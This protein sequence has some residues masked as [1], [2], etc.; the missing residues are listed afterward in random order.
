MPATTAPS[1]SG[2]ASPSPRPRRER[3]RRSHRAGDAGRRRLL[4]VDR[5]AVEVAHE[6]LLR[7]WPRL[8]TWLDEDVQG[9]RLH[10]RLGDA[11]R[12]WETNDQDPSELY[13]GTRLDGAVDWAAGHDADLNDSERA[14]LDASRTEAEREMAEAPAGASPTRPGPTG[15]SWACSPAS[16]CCSCWR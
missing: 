7:E 13:R 4:T 1:T 9:R 3:R 12:S 5:D 10:R 15:A 11:A 16:P 2:A 14:F 6:A 8:R